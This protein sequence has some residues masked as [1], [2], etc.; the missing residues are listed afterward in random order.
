[1]INWIAGNI[2]QNK[3]AFVILLM[4]AQVNHWSAIYDIGVQRYIVKK[5]YFAK[6]KWHVLFSNIICWSEFN[7]YFE[8]S[9]QL[10]FS[11]HFKEFQELKMELR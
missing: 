9:S 8:I 10:L 11:V 2:H 3:D 6:K 4:K 7:I 1:M 5:N